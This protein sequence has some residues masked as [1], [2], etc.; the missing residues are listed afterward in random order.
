MS[1]CAIAERVCRLCGIGPEF[2]EIGHGGFRCRLPPRQK[3]RFPKPAS[4][5]PFLAISRRSIPQKNHLCPKHA[6]RRAKPSRQRPQ[7]KHHTPCERSRGCVQTAPCPRAAEPWPGA[8]PRC[9]VRSEVSACANRPLVRDSRSLGVCETPLGA[10]EFPVSP[11]QSPLGRVSAGAWVRARWPLERANRALARVRSAL[12]SD[13][14]E[15]H[16]VIA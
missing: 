13:T 16:P 8:T 7:K 10:C 6:R 9:R 11:C 14:C 15:N 4:H 1:S 5:Y 12:A 3:R 2:G